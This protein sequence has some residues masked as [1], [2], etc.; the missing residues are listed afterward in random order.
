MHNCHAGCTKCVGLS[1]TMYEW[2]IYVSSGRE[3]TNHTVIHG[4]YKRLW[5]TLKMWQPVI[6]S[7]IYIF[8]FNTDND[9]AQ[10]VT[11]HACKP[12]YAGCARRTISG[13]QVHAHTR[14]H[15]HGV[16]WEA[17][18]A[19]CVWEERAHAHEREGILDS[20]L[21]EW[22][23]K[24]GAPARGEGLR[25]GGGGGGQ[26][27]WNLFHVPTLLGKVEFI[28]DAHVIGQKCWNL[29]QMPT[30]LGKVNLISG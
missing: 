14:Y 19:A 9:S 8:Q 20:V 3:I 1:R 26:R 2:C 21:E 13:C 12:L 15:R 24:R 11:F 10:R 23:V 7:H 27:C 30:L 22:D 16:C 17:P 6:P 5:Q 18:R 4:A 29:F 25:W 28:S